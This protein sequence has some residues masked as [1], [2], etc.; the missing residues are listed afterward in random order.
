MAHCRREPIREV[1]I[2]MRQMK[3]Q[4]HP[5]KLAKRIFRWYAGDVVAE[6]LTGDM[7]ELFYQN[8]QE[9]SSAKAK[10][11]YWTRVISLFGS[12][13]I[14]KRRMNA[15]FH[16]HSNN[17]V[18]LSMIKNYILIAWR[19]MSRNRVYSIINVLGLT[20]GITACIIV[21][22]VI[23]YAFSF[24][25][26]HPGYERIFRINTSHQGEQTWTRGG[27]HAAT[28]PILEDELTRVD[29]I[30]GVHNFDAKSSVTDNG[31]VKRFDRNSGSVVITNA[32][33]FDIFQYEWLAGNK[34]SFSEPMRAVITDS[35]AKAYFGSTEPQEVLGKVITYNDSLQVTV[36]GVVKD[37]TK[38]SDFVHSDFISFNTIENTF[39]RKEIRLDN[40]D[41]LWH[42]SQCYVKIKPGDNP[43]EV[44]DAITAI[45]K[46]RP[47]DTYTFK[48][49]PLKNIH[50][51]INDEG[52]GTIMPVLYAIA[53]LAIFILAI[54]A[55]NFIN[56]STAQSITRSREIGIRKVMGSGRQQIIVQFLCETTILAFIALLLS[57]ALVRPILYVLGDYIPRGLNFDPL[58]IN[59]WLFF[60]SLLV[61]ISCLAGIYPALIISSYRPT[62]NLTS[63]YVTIGRGAFSLRRALVVGQFTI[64]LFFITITLIVAGQMDFIKTKDRGFSTENVMTFRTNFAAPVSKVQTLVDRIRSFAGED[65]VT[66]QGFSPMGFAMMFNSFEFLSDKG[67]IE[68]ET[69]VKAGDEKYVSLYQ[70]RLVAGRNYFPADSV[71]EAIVNE[72][73]VKSVGIDDPHKIIGQQIKLNGHQLSICG[74]AQDFH[75][76]SF[77]NAIPPCLI[78]N[79]KNEEHGVAIRFDGDDFAARVL[80]ISKIEQAFKTVY[81][82]ETFSAHF[83]EDEISWMHQSEGMILKVAR[84]T[85]A[86]TIFIS[87]IGV[88][89]LAMFTAT[90]RTREIGIRKVLGASV[91]KIVRMLNTE[92]VVLIF[93][94]IFVATPLAWFTMYSLLADYT[95]HIPLSWWYFA[96]GGAIALLTALIT[97]SFQSW[98]AA[99]SDPVKALRS[100]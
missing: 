6:D 5:P 43:S 7:D 64:S 4:A 40:W 59:N 63:R 41:A 35:R 55:I 8:L 62:N 2:G 58:A 34:Q 11:R 70:I 74:V 30:A 51:I 10:W 57:M 85:M 32:E 80:L 37:W 72:A 66:M 17:I 83:I 91:W 18:N 15:S 46:G 84:A 75:Q 100:E 87:C 45:I 65:K 79:F 42:S 56:L 27:V 13:V 29:A 23:N 12:Y 25:R 48:L 67:P 22:L 33:Y 73:F 92:F 54:A 38:N 98:K 28:F 95:Y 78:A 49:E 69:S 90:R 76:Q 94:A 81:P 61:V 26:F 1:E 60:G 9:M 52:E 93:I 97:V 21:F 86:V 88:F 71:K 44:A 68:G 16:P 20:L 50:L 31:Q 39:L 89:G 77:R 24:D 96:S 99:T 19:V 36:A 53:A 47:N 82:D 3:R 14:K